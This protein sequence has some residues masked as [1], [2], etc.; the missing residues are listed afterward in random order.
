MLW[1]RI[2]G[3]NSLGLNVQSGNF[4]EVLFMLFAVVKGTM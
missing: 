1:N 4:G 2:R 3:G